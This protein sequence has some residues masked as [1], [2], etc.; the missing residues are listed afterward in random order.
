MIC[1]CFRQPNPCDRKH[2]LLN[3]VKFLLF[4]SHLLFYCNCFIYPIKPICPIHL[5]FDLVKE[6]VGQTVFWNDSTVLKKYS[7]SSFFGQC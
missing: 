6:M 4:F 2:S 3:S 7:K 1:D 5:A